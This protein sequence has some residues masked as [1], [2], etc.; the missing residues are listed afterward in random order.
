VLPIE[1]PPLRNRLGDIHALC[2]A[3]LEQLAFRSGLPQREIEPAAVELLKAHDWPG[4]VRELR[5]LL[6]RVSMLSD[7]VQLSVDDFAAV[8]P[9][10]STRPS[11][12]VTRRQAGR[13]GRSPKRSPRSRA[14]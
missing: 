1:I 10:D 6:E 12:Q 11:R 7:R 2:E 13:S 5:N 8:L 14:R 9:V 4:N 3:T